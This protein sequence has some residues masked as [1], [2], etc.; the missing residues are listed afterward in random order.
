MKKWS[1]EELDIAKELLKKGLRYKEIGLQI[2]RTNRS[3]KNKLEEVGVKYY[4]FNPTSEKR[5][6]L[7]C[8]IEFEAK[9]VEPN[10][11]CGSS[12]AAS[13]NNKNRIKKQKVNINNRKRKEYHARKKAKCINCRDITTNKYCG[14]KC[15]HEYK[16][17]KIFKE[18]ENGN[19]KLYFKNYKNY[20]IEKYGEKC[21]ECGWSE[22]NK[23]S[24]KIP[25]E[26]EHVDG[27]S[28]NNDLKNLKLLCPNCYS[29]TSTYK[30]LNK[31]N[32]R[33]K[34]MERYNQGKS[35]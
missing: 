1:N 6:C 30:A 5:N 18:I 32:G 17:N 31:G 8:K 13:F 12:C 25:I 19:T 23:Y 7:N 26:L 4:D 9:I 35:Y 29:L 20:L 24:N 27:N 3:V 33:H 2:N 15:Q 11:F 16:R 14:Q 10:K 28:K 21:M 22:K 34:R